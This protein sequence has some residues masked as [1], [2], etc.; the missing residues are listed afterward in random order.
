MRDSSNM[1]S[2][3][4]VFRPWALKV[5]AESFRVFF[6]FFSVPVEEVDCICGVDLEVVSLLNTATA[7]VI[8]WRVFF[9]HINHKKHFFKNSISEPHIWTRKMIYWNNIKVYLGSSSCRE[10]T[11]VPQASPTR[12]WQETHHHCRL[13]YFWCWS[14]IGDRGSGEQSW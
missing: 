10:T 3:E 11:L 1:L 2:A 8:C 13:H 14:A 9:V 5:T 7:H 12:T 6:C 4:W